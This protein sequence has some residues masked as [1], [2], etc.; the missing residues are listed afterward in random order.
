MGRLACQNDR[1]LID[2]IAGIVRMAKNLDI[3][4]LHGIDHRLRVFRFRML[5]AEAWNV[6]GCDR[7]VKHFQRAFVQIDMPFDI[8]HIQLRSFKHVDSLD[9]FRDDMKVAEVEQM[10]R[11]RHLRRMIADAVNR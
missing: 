5:G 4:I 6:Q 1:F 7:V 9:E 3:R 8:Q 11:T 10:R 2:R